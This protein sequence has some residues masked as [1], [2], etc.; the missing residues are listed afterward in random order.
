MQ[1]RRRLTW[2]PRD[3]TWRMTVLFM[4]GSALFAL[5]SFPAY[6]SLVDSRVVA[7]TFVVGAVF[8]TTAAYHQYLEVV[9]GSG[10]G[11][12]FRWWAWGPRTMLWW[13][14]LVQLV[15]TLFF[16]AN[17][18][19][20]MATHL[21]THQANRLV[22]A[23]D[24]FGSIA[25]LVASQL[26]WRAVCPRQWCV[27]RDDPDWW[28]ALLNYVGSVFFMLSA[29]GAFILPTT[30]EP[31]NLTVVNSGTFLGAVCFFAGAYV[32]LPARRPATR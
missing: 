9:N 32:L 7:A 23:P 22:W 4:V 21:T 6:W 16:N 5:G 28:S 13:A 10:T 12:R 18:I 15:G 14:A 20:A 25:F 3:L 8:F 19:A 2:S 31:V 1:W 26:A 24:F 27:R 11:T 29:L 17:T 30:G